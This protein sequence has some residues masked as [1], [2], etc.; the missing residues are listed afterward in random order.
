M[1]ELIMSHNP[2][3]NLT[4]PQA[5]D[6]GIKIRYASYEYSCCSFAMLESRKFK[7]RS[8]DAEHLLSEYQKLGCRA[9]VPIT[10]ISFVLRLLRFR[11]SPSQ[12]FSPRSKPTVWLPKALTETPMD[13]QHWVTT[14]PWGSCK[15]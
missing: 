3:P 13:G 8:G 9:G 12:P 5:L 1:Q 15:T 14:M 4:T 2:D 6:N 7:S 10:R 11:L